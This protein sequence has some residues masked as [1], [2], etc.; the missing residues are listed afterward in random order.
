MQTIKPSIQHTEKEQNALSLSTLLDGIGVAIA[1]V[2]A[3]GEVHFS[4]KP[5]RALFEQAEGA[6]SLKILTPQ[7]WD[8]LEAV[9]QA[10]HHALYYDTWEGELTLAVPHETAIVHLSTVQFKGRKLLQLTLQT[11]NGQNTAIQRTQK[12]EKLP[13]EAITIYQSLPWAV[14]LS[15]PKHPS[16]FIFVNTA[17]CELVG[18]SESDLC[19]NAA[20]IQ[21]LYGSVTEYHLSQRLEE[22]FRFQHKL[23]HDVP[24]QCANR[25]VVYCD[26][27]SSFLELNG[28]RYLVSYFQE[29]T[30]RHTA[31]HRLAE[32]DTE[33]ALTQSLSDT[34]TWRWDLQTGK[35]EWSE[36]MYR[37][38]N[39]DPTQR[40]PANKIL[41]DKIAACDRDSVLASLEAKIDR[42]QELSLQFQLECGGQTFPVR[43][44]GKVIGASE[45]ASGIFIGIIQDLRKEYAAKKA[46]QRSETIR[47][48]AA[49]IANV[50]YWEYDVAS[51]HM[52]W[53]NEVFRI[54]HHTPPSAKT[55]SR[56]DYHNLIHPRDKKG[57]ESTY[58]KAIAQQEGFALEYRIVLPNGRLA[59]LLERAV[60]Q[61]EKEGSI[62]L[63]GTVQDITHHKEVENAL[64]YQEYLLHNVNDAIISTN[65]RM[66]IK[67]WNEA[68]AEIY[69][70]K[71]EEVIGKKI[72]DV[73]DLPQAD[74][75]TME[76]V[77]KKVMKEGFWKGNLHQKTKEGAAIIVQSSSRLLRD[78]NGFPLGIAT[79]NRDITAFTQIEKQAQKSQMMLEMI[80][81]SIPGWI[82]WEDPDLVIRGCNRHFTEA[83]GKQNASEIV[84]K[85]LEELIEDGFFVRNAIAASHS[86]MHD[87]KSQYHQIEPL[88]HPTGIA[89][90]LDINRLPLYDQQGAVIGV[91]CTAE[92]ITEKKEIEAKLKANQANLA[93]V[94][95][96]T[97]DLIWYVDQQHRFQA[98]NSAVSNKVREV[99]GHEIKTNDSFFSVLPPLY[100]KMFRDLHD[101]V[102]EGKKLSKEYCFGENSEHP[103]WYEFSG[104]PIFDGD[105]VSGACYI[106][107]DISVRKQQEAQLLAGTINKEKELSLAVVQGQEEERKRIS[108]ELHDGVCQTLTALQMQANYLDGVQASY[109]EEQLNPLVRIIQLA[110]HAE[111]EVR[112][113]SSNLMPSVLTDFG[114]P[115][116]VDHLC[117]L[118]FHNTKIHCEVDV[119]L[120]GKRFPNT[121]EVGIFRI[122][123]EILNNI[124]KHSGATHVSITLLDEGSR[125]FLSVK[126]NGKGFSQEEMN[127]RRKHRNGLNN[128][129]QR[130]SLLNGSL[131]IDSVPG[132]GCE[133]SAYVPY[134]KAEEQP[135]QA[136]F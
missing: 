2:S 27:H 104:N 14:A 116:A 12:S 95:E 76:N 65:I 64:R 10:F 81:D 86:V 39:E 63:V 83:M 73:L 62:L 70:W 36:G 102:M 77:L 100:R 49:A 125:L 44:M 99:L 37:L 68:A 87:Q 4:N 40:K 53:S 56:E 66:E 89:Y 91:M 6:S 8:D 45:T 46:L 130:V 103:Q 31:I 25:S 13:L 24:L 113:I 11:S 90:W 85:R 134:P 29:V 33:I 133:I 109:A 78:T 72:T 5:F 17:F 96:N 43:L 59:Y 84:G 119:M 51:Q 21:Q 118:I 18:Y 22:S 34:G 9:K 3:Y 20:L 80:F 79:V 129:T 127:E 136:L 114:L 108:M 41:F 54:C 23:L 135:V 131:E 121:V 112:R 26:V 38:L 7:L 128:L 88:R 52:R 97:D 58:Q 111:K 110:D 32:L 92:D 35:V 1:I 48:R 71:S 124:Y 28:R 47:K 98:F 19:E 105:A 82:F 42:R 15:N 101:E 115:E 122:L 107:R 120:H 94:I 126:D 93:S 57:V 132:N 60:V 106:A 50:G 16:H 117:N 30:D 61:K 123:Q 69:G 67:S 75:F 55:F 74:G